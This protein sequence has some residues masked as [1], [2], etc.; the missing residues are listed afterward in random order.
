MQ[1]ALQDLLE[2][3]NI[4]RQRGCPTNDHH[5]LRVEMESDTTFCT[6]WCT[7]CGWMD[8]V[9]IEEKW[10]GFK[11]AED[12][13]NIDVYP[14]LHPAS[15]QCAFIPKS[16]PNVEEIKVWAVFRNNGTLRHER[17]PLIPTDSKGFPIECAIVYFD[18]KTALECGMAADRSNVSPAIIHKISLEK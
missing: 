4:V 3:V 6:I 18:E 9:T 14:V 11:E 16:I 17:G 1:T 7:E 12:Q 8:V 15:N 10:N 5:F 13:G 2:K